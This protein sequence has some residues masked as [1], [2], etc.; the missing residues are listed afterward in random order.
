MFGPLTRLFTIIYFS[1]LSALGN[2][3]YSESEDR[4]ILSA[5]EDGIRNTV[6]TIES[7]QLDDRQFYNCT[8]T[9]VAVR[10][11]N[12]NY[13]VAV[14]AIY[15][16]VKGS[17]KNNFKLIIAEK[18]FLNVYRKTGCSLAFPWNMR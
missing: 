11:G 16:R 1:K 18:I 2:R 7:A 13:D 9:N 8:G 5:N 14:E 12:A 4:V 10:Y 17:Y 3:T 15:V 6:L